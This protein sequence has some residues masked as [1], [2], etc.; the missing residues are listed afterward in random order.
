[1]DRTASELIHNVPTVQRGFGHVVVR[2]VRDVRRR[3][4]LGV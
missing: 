2:G 1:M 4:V 3:G